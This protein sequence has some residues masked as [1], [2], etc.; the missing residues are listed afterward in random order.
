MFTGYFD[1]ILMAMFVVGVILVLID[2]IQTCLRNINNGKSEENLVPVHL[3][4]S[5][6]SFQ[7]RINFAAAAG[8]ELALNGHLRPATPKDGERYRAPKRCSNRR[9]RSTD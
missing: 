3:F 9:H 5:V 7:Y 1:S 6:R 4:S 2:A 8:R